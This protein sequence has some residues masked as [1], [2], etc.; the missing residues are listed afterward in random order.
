MNLFNDDIDVTKFYKKT[1]WMLRIYSSIL[2]IGC[3]IGSIA[4]LCLDINKF[5]IKFTMFGYLFGS[6]IGVEVFYLII[7]SILLRFVF[8]DEINYKHDKN[9][10]I[11][12]PSQTM[13]D[14][15]ETNDIP[16]I[17]ENSEDTSSCISEDFENC[18]LKKP[19]HSMSA[20]K[21][22]S[23]LILCTIVTFI[24]VALILSI[25]FAK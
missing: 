5:P 1:F 18:N 8:R 21:K 7:T 20:E 4:F 16:Q 13:N 17:E 23:I 2:S 11:K 12:S 15:Q 24:V 25:V 3:F 9:I 19:K 22:Y 10:K 6:S 14:L